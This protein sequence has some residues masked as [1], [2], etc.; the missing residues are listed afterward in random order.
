MDGR[1]HRLQLGAIVQ[2]IYVRLDEPRRRTCCQDFHVLRSIYRFVRVAWLPFRT[3]KRFEVVFNN[4]LQISAK[5][6]SLP[7]CIM[8]V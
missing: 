7:F 2:C 8:I 3:K 4:D 1:Q 5:I 6:D